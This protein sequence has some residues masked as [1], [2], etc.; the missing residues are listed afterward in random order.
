M[1]LIIKDKMLATAWAVFL[2]FFFWWL[3][4]IVIRGSG[5]NDFT[6]QVFGQFYGLMALVGACFGFV[7]SKK[8]GGF[9]SAIG[10]ALIAFSIGLLLQE[11]GQ[12]SYTYYILVDK[13]EIPYPS[14]GDIGYFGSIIFY[15]YGVLMLAK[16]SGVHTTFNTWKG[17]FVAVGLPVLFL[18]LAYWS[19]LSGQYNFGSENILAMMLTFG[20]PLGQAVYISIALTTIVLSR[21]LLGGI[22]KSKVEFILIALMVQFAADYTFLY[23]T[24]MGTWTAGGINDFMYLVAYFVMTIALIRMKLVF[25]QVKEGE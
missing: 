8:W 18:G 6:N 24:K 11:F 3:Y 5:I 15:I 22:M 17:R 14:L 4:F 20:Y 23:Q 12:L 25:D 2:F 13:I 7:I 10:K 16:A 21:G 9:K 19:F 1:K